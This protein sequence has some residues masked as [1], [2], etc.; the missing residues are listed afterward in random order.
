[1]ADSQAHSLL[2]TAG[3]AGANHRQVKR[4]RCQDAGNPALR[5]PPGKASR[6]KLPQLDVGGGGKEEGQ[7]GDWT[8]EHVE[9]GARPQS[10]SGNGLVQTARAARVSLLA[11]AASGVQALGRPLRCS[12]SFIGPWKSRALSAASVAEPL[13]AATPSICH[14]PPSEARCGAP[15]PGRQ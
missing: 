4:G 10:S 14:A 15:P 1:M 8:S 12:A 6:S 9:G 13:Q 11:P 2:M 7:Q 3:T 5:N